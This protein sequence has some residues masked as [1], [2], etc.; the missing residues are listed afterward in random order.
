MKFQTPVLANYDPDHDILN[1]RPFHLFSIGAIIYSKYLCMASLTTCPQLRDSLELQVEG[2][3]GDPDRKLKLHRAFI[4][5][6]GRQLSQYKTLQEFGNVLL[7]I[8]KR[9]R[10]LVDQG[11]LHRDFSPWNVY[12]YDTDAPGQESVPQGGE[13]FISNFDA[14]IFQTEMAE[15]TGTISISGIVPFMATEV[16]GE[17]VA[18]KPAVKRQAYHDLESLCWVILY[19]VQV[20]FVE[21]GPRSSSPQAKKARE[22]LKSEHEPVFDATSSRATILNN[23]IVFVKPTDISGTGLDEVLTLANETGLRSFINVLYKYLKA[24]VDRYHA[25]TPTVHLAPPGGS[26]L[27]ELDM[28]VTAQLAPPTALMEGKLTHDIL[29]KLARGL[30]QVLDG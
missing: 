24:Q 20:R 16:L 9:H 27:A 17:Y 19:S 29:E 5:P 25:S 6:M 11:I 15:I 12:I 8:V 10:S 13:G 30:L 14:A 22:R 1:H 26:L 28:Q 7:A 4:T 18:E 23:R 3:E 2:G 21:D